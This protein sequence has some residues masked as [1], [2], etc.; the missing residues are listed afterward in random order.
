MEKE[1]RIIEL[2]IPSE[3]GFEKMATRLAAAVAQEMGFASDRVEDLK[4]AVA[5]AC[6]NAIEH[7]NQLDASTRVLVLLNIDDDRLAIDVKDEGRSG[8]PPDTVPKPDI[9][10]KVAGQEALRQMGMYIIQ[11][12]VDEAGFVEPELGKGS[13][14]RMVIHLQRHNSTEQGGNE[15]QESCV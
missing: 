14:F 6:L 10:R 12:L 9:G 7:G 1:T 4:T 15:E 2:R 11:H 8:P 3:F 5:E 13:Q